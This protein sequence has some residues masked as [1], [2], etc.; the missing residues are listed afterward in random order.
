MKFRPICK[1]N[2]Q[3]R[4]QHFLTH[5]LDKFMSVV[6]DVQIQSNNKDKDSIRV[7]SVDLNDM[8]V[9]ITKQKITQINIEYL[10]AIHINNNLQN[11]Q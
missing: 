11:P 8:P 7:S 9:I 10:E 6:A 4:L 2:Y 3:T 5:D 1:D